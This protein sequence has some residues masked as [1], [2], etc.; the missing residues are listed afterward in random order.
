MDIWYDDNISSKH[1]H[2]LKNNMWYRDSSLRTQVLGSSN[3]TKFTNKGGFT[4][5]LI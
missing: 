1:S 4:L 3:S 2:D 5:G